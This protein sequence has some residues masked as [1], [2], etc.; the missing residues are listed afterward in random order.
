M[1]KVVTV[2]SFLLASLLLVNGCNG[3]ESSSSSSIV[4][5]S[6][7]SII[8]VDLGPI[9]DE[10][11]EKSEAPL[12][13]GTS[14]LR[15]TFDVKDGIPYQNDIVY[16]YFD[17]Q[18]SIYIDL[19]GTWYKKRIENF[20]VNKKASL[21][22]TFLGR[23]KEV[24]RKFVSESQGYL[25]GDFDKEQ[26]DTI[27]LPLPENKLYRKPT[28]DGVEKYEMGTWYYKEININEL[29]NSSYILKS[30]GSNYVTDLF[31]NGYYVGYHEG[32][33]TPFAF[34]IS[35]FLKE[36]VNSLSLRVHGIPFGMRSDTIPGDIQ[37]T[38]YFNYTGPMQ[39][40]Y[41]EKLPLAHIARVDALSKDTL[42]GFDVS[43]VIENKSLNNISN[44]IKYILY[45]ADQSKYLNEVSAKSIIGDKVLENEIEN[46]S[47]N[48]N[49]VEK[50]EFSIYLDN[51]KLWDVND[52]NLYV[53]EVN[54]NN[55]T[56]Y[57]Q[58]GLRTVKT[59]GT[60]IH[61]N[62]ASTFFA[63]VARH[64]ESM[65]YGRTFNW[66]TVIN[67]LDI[68]KELGANFVRTG[69]YPNQLY[70]YILLDRYGLASAV[71]LPIWQNDEDSYK[72]IIKRG[73]GL[74]IWREMIFSNYNSPSVIFWSTQN[75]AGARK[76]RLELNEILASDLKE[77]YNDG[78]LVMQSAA[79]DRPG[80]Y[81]NTTVP[82]DVP[83]YT[84]YFET[85]HGDVAY[86][87]T[88]K[89]LVN[90]R[91]NEG[92]KDKPAMNTEY[93]YWEDHSR[94]FRTLQADMEFATVNKDGTINENGF[95]AAVVYWTIADWYVNH[96]DHIQGMG[97]VSIKR[98]KKSLFYKVQA[99]YQDLMKNNGKALSGVTK[100]IDKNIYNHNKV[101]TNI[102][103]EIDYND[104]NK[105]NYIVF[106]FDK[107]I[108]DEKLNLTLIGETTYPYQID[109]I[110]SE[111]R[112]PTS[113]LVR[114]A[115]KEGKSVIKITLSSNLST[116]L[117]AV[118]LSDSIFEIF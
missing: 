14:S 110:F 80:P 32:G 81:D 9:F 40:M 55:Q 71:E 111:V 82:L 78:R 53:L 3:Q 64:E 69:H 17:P 67:D 62:N 104:L 114:Y 116:H 59:V 44:N 10:L 27:E 92:S 46:I 52:P 15:M 75:E 5:S 31:V 25:R 45:E 20:D 57:H 89:F 95:V 73:I 98:V 112:I 90:T 13:P 2:C 87:G 61:L 100:D 48:S 23:S 93:G 107:D 108:L 77:N 106:S 109:T 91:D 38:D 16:P 36:G 39:L 79:A 66:E 37:G 97:L 43:V 70:T 47:V 1:T 54:F 102:E 84:L 30:L 94:I 58:L 65:N 4:Q 12:Q 60:H 103:I 99:I 113:F 115:K 101:D 105:Y 34:D 21:D 24:V 72:R 33:H 76:S 28:R 56:T 50:V 49:D 42:D 11:P 19:S 22:L 35:S 83:G 63:G 74:Q 118:K 51:P 29:T 117:N 86:G 18:D 68:I 88:R 6:P 96:Q 41:I 8:N 85:F 26:S 7:S